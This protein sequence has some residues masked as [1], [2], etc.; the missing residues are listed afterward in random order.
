MG[1]GKDSSSKYFSGW[2][3]SDVRFRKD[4]NSAIV[5][6][7]RH[8][9]SHGDTRALGELIEK[10]PDD[11]L[12]RRMSRRLVQS[13]PI[14]FDRQKGT[15]TLRKGRGPFDWLAVEHVNVFDPQITASPSALKVGNVELS[16]DEFVDECLD[17]MILARRLLTQDHLSRL[18]EA[19]TKI[20]ARR[21][22]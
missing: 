8:I 17:A 3:P 9:A 10:V 15:F 1:K 12:R 13:L 2:Y 7:L 5:G 14:D 19:L 6:A 4:F 21:Q 11:E 16:V 18:S 22:G 20:A